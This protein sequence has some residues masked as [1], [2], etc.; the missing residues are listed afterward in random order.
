VVN[1]VTVPVTGSIEVGFTSTQPTAGSSRRSTDNFPASAAATSALS[2]T[3]VSATGTEN[4]TPLG[5]TW[6]TGPTI[7]AGGGV[8]TE[9][10]SESVTVIGALVA[11]GGND[12]L[13]PASGLA[14]SVTATVPPSVGVTGAATEVSQLRPSPVYPALHAQV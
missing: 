7:S 8:G 12:T 3:S 9:T 14:G 2:Y 11:F 1:T 10:G 6:V 4:T 13:V 5:D